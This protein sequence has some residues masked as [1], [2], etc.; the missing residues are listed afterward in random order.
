MKGRS[1]TVFNASRAPMALKGH[2]SDQSPSKG[3]I[4][5]YSLA[6]IQGSPGLSVSDTALGD[7][8]AILGCPEP[9]LRNSA[10]LQ[11]TANVQ[12]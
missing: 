5:D 7:C 6:R 12:E 2:W 1:A 4:R 11:E 3:V 8:I 10:P 9:M